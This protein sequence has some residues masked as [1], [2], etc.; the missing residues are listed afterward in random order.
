MATLMLGGERYECLPGETV[1]EAL[2]RQKVEV[3]YGCKQGICQTCLLRSDI[4]P[5]DNVQI[6]L[7]TDQRSKNCFLACQWQA[8]EDISITPVLSHDFVKAKVVSKSLLRQDILKLTLK[9]QKPFKFHAGQFVNLKKSE[10]VVRS[11]SIANTPN[12]ENTVEFHIRLL[13]NGQFSQ[14]AFSEL[15]AGDVIP[16]SEPKGSC[17]YSPTES[18]GNL[19][20][21]GTGT[22]LAP[23]SGVL[24]D[25]LEL[26]HT[27]VI[28][29]FHGSQY[30]EGLYLDTELNQL[31]E[32]YNNFLYTGCVS[33]GHSSGFVS[34]RAND[35]AFLEY[36]DLKGWKVFICGNPDMVKASQTQAFLK[37]ASCQNIYSDAFVLSQ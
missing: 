6:N 19:L 10:S 7:T 5:P 17:I 22:G 25:A 4:A 23:L 14:W 18:T 31:A 11:Y 33:K 13:A 30:S 35:R 8:E 29:L 37:G 3:S 15:V 20:M 16:V 9:V 28:H 24:A 12:Q 36:P 34:G 21:I 26:K 2:L 32:Q 1:L 27:G